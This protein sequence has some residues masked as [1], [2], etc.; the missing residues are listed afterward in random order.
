M[1]APEPTAGV[2]MITVGGLLMEH[3]DALASALPGHPLTASV[4][5]ALAGI[6]A[7]AKANPAGCTSCRRARYKAQVGREYVVHSHDAS[8]HARVAAITGLPV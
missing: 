5:A 3:R 1:S 6:E 8:L 7:E 2:S 4:D